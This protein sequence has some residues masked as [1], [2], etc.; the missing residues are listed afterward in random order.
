MPGNENRIQ[1]CIDENIADILQCYGDAK[2]N[3]VKAATYVDR[4]NQGCTQLEWTTE[5]AF[6]YFHNSVCGEADDWLKS[7]LF[8]FKDSPLTWT[9]LKPLFCE[10]FDLTCVTHT[11]ILR[12]SNIS[13]GDYEGNIEKYYRNVQNILAAE[14]AQYEPAAVEIPDDLALNPAQKLFVQN[15]FRKG[16]SDVFHTLV[17]ECFMNGLPTADFNKLKNKD[18]LQMAR[19]LK[20]YL[21]KDC[22]LKQA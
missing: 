15:T 2:L 17:Q 9:K 1:Q 10:R 21:Q 19:D 11:F 5:D 12:I 7:Y 14:M 3:T 13:L 20:D 22:K 16:A 8:N 18:N 4:I 6:T